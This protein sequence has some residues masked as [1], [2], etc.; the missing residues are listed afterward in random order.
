[1]IRGSAFFRVSSIWKCLIR[2]QRLYLSYLWDNNYLFKKIN[3]LGPILQVTS[4][5]YN[6]PISCTSSPLVS[7]FLN[8]N[9]WEKPKLATWTPEAAHG[10]R[11][12][13]FI[14]RQ[15]V[16]FR[17]TS[18]ARVRRKWNTVL[19]PSPQNSLMRH[20]KSCLRDNY[21]SL[22]SEILLLA[23]VSQLI[24]WWV[25]PWYTW[26]LR[27]WMTCLTW[28]RIDPFFGNRARS[29]EIGA[30]S[31]ATLSHGGATVEWIIVGNAALDKLPKARWRIHLDSWL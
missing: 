23:T 17:H 31:R 4:I 21:C 25:I 16:T 30:L 10:V 29:L 18:S 22:L 1:M 9:S 12:C 2:Q 14:N 28:S 11:L 24:R 5:S 19:A 13:L 8:K 20:A 27:K 6:E 26:N 15:Q 7:F 3:S